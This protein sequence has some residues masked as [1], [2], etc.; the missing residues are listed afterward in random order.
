MNMVLL[1]VM[2]MIMIGTTNPTKIQAVKEVVETSPLF[3]EMKVGSCASESG[4]SE[5][6]MS[7]EETIRGAKNR[8]RNAFKDCKYSVG[9]ESGLMDAPGSNTGM[10]EFCVCAI[11][12]GVHYGIG[13]SCG[14]ELPKEVLRLI[15]EKGM[16]LGEAYLHSGLTDN[17]KLGAAEGAIG[18]LTRM[19]VTRKDYTKQAIEMA[20]IQFENRPFYFP[21]SCNE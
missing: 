12:D 3:K 2:Q 11:Y 1:S 20:L 7:C 19:R 4:V 9:L 17:P 15:K 8:A 18:L 6:P 5:Q 16:D 13:T 10:I 21:A 14:F